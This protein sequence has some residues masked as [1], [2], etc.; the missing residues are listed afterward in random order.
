MTQQ[1]VNNI[2]IV[3]I[4]LLIISELYVYRSIVQFYY[5]FI[6]TRSR[7]F[8]QYGMMKRKAKFLA[9]ELDDHI[10]IRLRVKS[11]FALI[12]CVLIPA[13]AD[14]FASRELYGFINII[15]GIHVF[16]I[17]V[18]TP[19]YKFLTRDNIFRSLGHN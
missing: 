15:S 8:S 13:L 1:L 5:D 11:G 6:K 16:V 4:F 12:L 10:Q 19:V 2:F 17:I 9:S 7:S 18:E 3:I 14:K